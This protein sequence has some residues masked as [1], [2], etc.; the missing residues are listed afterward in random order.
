[1]THR[2][3]ARL[4]TA[5]LLM[6]GVLVVAGA[7]PAEATPVTV[8]VRYG[9]YTIPANGM[10]ENQFSANVAKPCGNCWII[11]MT[12]DLEYQD[13]SNANV[14]SGAMLHHFVLFN[15]DRTDATCGGSS[16]GQ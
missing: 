6:V 13:G 11:G 10:I 12:P 9:P 5:L 7:R 15:Q 2:K 8:K 1:M 16:I 14:D 3:A 4:G